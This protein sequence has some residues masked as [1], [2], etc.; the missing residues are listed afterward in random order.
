[1]R[2]SEISYSV[3]PSRGRSDAWA[4]K[5]D[6]TVFLSPAAQMSLQLTEGSVSRARL[7]AVH[8]MIVLFGCLNECQELRGSFFDKGE[9]KDRLVQPCVSAQEDGVV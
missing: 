4:A 7:A 5:S 6:V 1:M 8:E 2:E 3:Q 9:C